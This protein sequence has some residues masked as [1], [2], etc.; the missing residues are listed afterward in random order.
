MGP[1]SKV[2]N[3]LLRAAC[4]ASTVAALGSACTVDYLIWIPR[5]PDADPLYRFEQNHKIGYIDQHGKVLISPV[6]KDW[7][8]NS[9]GEFHS[10]LL[11]IGVSDGI[12]VDTTGKTVIHKGLY[13]GWDFSEGFAAAMQ[14]DS[15]KWG[16][17]DTHGDFVISPRFETYPRGSV[18][19]FEGG[20]A[21]IDVDGKIGYIDPTGSFAI[22]P[23][24]L[25]G[26]SFHDGMARV[27]VEG[28]CGYVSE[29]GGC[30]DVGV[31]PKNATSNSAPPA[32]KYTFVDAGGRIISEQRFDYARHFAEG[33]APV[34][35]G[36][37]WGYLD[38][39][40][41]IVIAPRFE[42]A[43]AFSDGL[44]RVSKG[45]LTGYVTHSG[46]FAITPRFKYAEDFADHRAVVGDGASA[47]WYIAHSGQKAIPE[48]YA[49]A[50]S[51]FKGLAHVKLTSATA[52]EEF[53]RKGTF[54]YI[55]PD[56]KHVFVY[57]RD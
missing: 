33:L 52:G 49:L 48:T 12:Y 39:K 29:D 55:T 18:L 24:F 1:A 20:L 13:R 54:A 50:S 47:Y 15:N 27:I 26:D 9:G 2:W 42:D 31:L 32:C 40:G 30:P 25:Q 17:I 7:G 4:L 37:L 53:Y 11:E 21:Q 16:Y 56:G 38:K 28:P 46:E 23:R 19:P 14:K 8:D 43:A 10:G 44:A 57:R 41:T 35:L 3:R 36:G 5:S 45:G 51:F 22:P 34:K 6:L